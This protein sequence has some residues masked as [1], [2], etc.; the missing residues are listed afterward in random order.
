M[1]TEKLTKAQ[2]AEIETKYNTACI[3]IARIIKE[4]EPVVKQMLEAEQSLEAH[5]LATR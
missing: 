3:E 4:S 2:L 5:V 1:K